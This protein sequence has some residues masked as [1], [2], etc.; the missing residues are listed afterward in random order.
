MQIESAELHGKGLTE[1]KDY[2]TVSD[3]LLSENPGILTV[4]DLQ[5]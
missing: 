4:N 3:V 2:S 5:E 1:P